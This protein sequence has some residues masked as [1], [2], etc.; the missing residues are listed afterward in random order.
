M[1]LSIIIPTH[2][3]AKYIEDAISSALNVRGQVEVIVSDNA[4]VDDTWNIISKFQDNKVRRY[5][6]DTKMSMAAHYEF[7]IA[8]AKG[9]WVTIIGDDDGI[10]PFA[11]EKLIEILDAHKNVDVITTE[12]SYYFWDG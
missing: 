11:H 4:S 1:L 6:H 3:G 2:N 7:C 5:S 8:K 9:D 10:L 12:Q